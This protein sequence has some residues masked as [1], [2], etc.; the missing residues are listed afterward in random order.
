MYYLATLVSCTYTV[1]S[2]VEAGPRDLGTKVTQKLK[3]NVKLVF[4]YK[5]VGFN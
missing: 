3:Q 5:N 2:V 4:L 1:D